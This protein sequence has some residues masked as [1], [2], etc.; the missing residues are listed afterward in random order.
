MRSSLALS[1]F[2]ALLLGCSMHVETPRL[3]IQSAQLVGAGTGGVTFRT[4]FAAYN[5][6]DFE[7]PLRDLQATLT[8]AGTEAGTSVTI[9]SATLPPLREVPVQTD[10][11]IPLSSLP[12]TAIAAF[13]QP[14]IEYT[15]DGSVTVHHY[16]TVRA[17]FRLNGRMPSTFLRQTATQSIN[18]VLGAFGVQVQ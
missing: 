10:I 12:A 9:L 14:E 3:T 17:S 16:L 6:N 4:T 5:P 15:L 7:L 1:A 11:T 13:T 18:S 2:A 8:L